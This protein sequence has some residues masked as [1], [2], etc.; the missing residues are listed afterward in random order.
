MPSLFHITSEETRRDAIRALEVLDLK[1]PQTM[2]L[3]RKVKRRTLNQNALLHK[4]ITIMA[5]DCGYTIDEMKQALKEELLEPIFYEALGKRRKRW[6]ST[7]EMDTKA[8]SDFMAKID[9]LAA[10]MGIALPRPE[11]AHLAA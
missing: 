4:W 9:I 7:A 3:K 1:W 8:L 5:E 10:K 2:T 11:E 6:P